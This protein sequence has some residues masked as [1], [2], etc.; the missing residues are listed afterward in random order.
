VSKKIKNV[1]RTGDFA[2]STVIFNGPVFKLHPKIV[3]H[4]V[5]LVSFQT[6]FASCV[7]K[8]TNYLTL[9]ITYQFIN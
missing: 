1:L 8:V 4:I 2:N 9:N 5:S 7:T 3:K 6:N